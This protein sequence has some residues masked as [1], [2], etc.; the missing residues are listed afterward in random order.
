VYGKARF[1]F[2][3]YFVLETFGSL[4]VRSNSRNDPI[5]ILYSFIVVSEPEIPVLC[6]F[7]NG[8]KDSLTFAWQPVE[9]A[10]S[11]RVVGDGVDE[12]SSVNTITVDGLTPGSHYTFT[13]WAVDSQEIPSDEITCTNSTGINCEFYCSIWT[14]SV[15]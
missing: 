10:T 14:I 5:R 6:V 8:T 1:Q 11:Y 4:R 7:V 15:F 2:L 13:V 3:R 12:T 9:F